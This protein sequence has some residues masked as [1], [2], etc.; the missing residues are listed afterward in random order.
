MVHGQPSESNGQENSI[1]AATI[2]PPVTAAPQFREKKVPLVAPFSFLLSIAAAEHGTYGTD[3][4]KCP[5]PLQKP[6][7]NGNNG[8]G[9]ANNSPKEAERK[10]ATLNLAPILKGSSSLCRRRRFRSTPP[11]AAHFRESGAR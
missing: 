9:R 7:S 5:P 2:S 10:W 4:C 8:L 1:A 3:R 11:A 6:D